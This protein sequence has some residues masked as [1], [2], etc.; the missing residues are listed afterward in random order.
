MDASHSGSVLSRLTAW[1]FS[2]YKTQKSLHPH[3]H[4]GDFQFNGRSHTLP[5]RV[6]MANLLLRR[7][8]KVY[9][10]ENLQM[11]FGSMS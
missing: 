6:D 1:G 10:S 5:N 3:I 9:L 7:I 2:G 8:E 4:L 11:A